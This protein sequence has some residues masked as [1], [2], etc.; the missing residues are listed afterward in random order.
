MLSKISRDRF[1]LQLLASKE[2]IISPKISIS[3]KLEYPSFQEFFDVDEKTALLKLGELENADLLKRTLW[4]TVLTCPR[5]KSL[6]LCIVL[7]CPNCGSTR[8][9]VTDLVSCPVCNYKEKAYY[10]YH[11]KAIRCPKCN[12]SLSKE[13]LVKEYRCQDCN[14]LFS[15]PELV[16][17]CPTC[18]NT[19]KEL[20]LEERSIFSYSIGANRVEKE[21]MNYLKEVLGIAGGEV[22]VPGIVTGRSGIRH[23]FTGIVR[24]NGNVSLAVEVLASDV[25]VGADD[26]LRSLVKVID[27]NPKQS[28]F[29][30]IPKVSSEAR[31]ILRSN[32]VRVVESGSVEEA[33]NG[34][35]LIIREIFENR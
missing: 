14:S 16:Y 28:I 30:V 1:L 32:K 6:A 35:R 19:Y 24:S 10:F 34:L 23:V 5:C 27:V 21:F 3:S 2:G 17:Y 33:I 11:G 13:D 26:V 18:Q 20:S 12:E 31:D 7:S 4:G 29:V 8:V 22:E 15:K 9:E 25:Y